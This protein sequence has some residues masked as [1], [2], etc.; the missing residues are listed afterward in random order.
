VSNDAGSMSG[1]LK[2]YADGFMAALAAQG[3]AAGTVML[4]RQVLGY[5]SRW[6]GTHAFEADVLGEGL[7]EE[8]LTEH[9]AT[10][11]HKRLR[12]KSFASL[13]AYLRGVGI[14]GASRDAPVGEVDELLARFGGYLAK[15]R[16]L[17]PL[18][19]SLRVKLVRPFLRGLKDSRGLDLPSLTADDVTAFIVA[20]SQI[21][22]ASVPST[23]TALR[24]LLRFLHV[25]AVI[26][27]DLASAVPTASGRSLAGPP[28]ALPAEQVTAMLATCDQTTAVGRRNLAILT[29]LSRLGLRSGEVASLRLEHIDWRRGEVMI[30][31]KGSRHDR[32]PLPRDAGSAIVAYLQGGRPAAG[33]REVFLCARGPHRPMHPDTVSNVGAAAARNAGLGIVRGHRLRH[34][35]ATAMLAAGGSLTEI[36]QVLRHQH[37]ATTAVYAKVDIAGLRRVARP[38]P[39]PETAA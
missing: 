16:G 28:K 8:F 33:Y 13:L 22:P 39:T 1:P 10:G 34:S 9:H 2:P 6:L 18:T 37:T 5:L 27:T 12:V 19:V 32:L 35:A 17:A 14:I 21:R 26:S 15:E 4:H 23:V 7:I 20:E 36:G 38:W 3:Y 29:L 30:T 31:G 25:E 11:L 24:S